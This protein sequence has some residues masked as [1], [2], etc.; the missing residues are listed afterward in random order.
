YSYLLTSQL[1]S[2]RIYWE[3]KIVHLEKETAEE[4]NN[5]KAKFKETL[6][7]C[8]NLEQRLG[9]ISKEKQSLEKKYVLLL[10]EWLNSRVV[11]LSQELKEE[12]EMNRCLRANQTQLQTQL[13]E[14]E[15]KGK[16]SGKS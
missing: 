13:A 11:K 15:R 14:E 7:R 4:I 6:E 12:Q 2:Q 8:D 5:M 16:E 9:E 1:E 10:H 3:N